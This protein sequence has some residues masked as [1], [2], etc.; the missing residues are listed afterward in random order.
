MLV[1]DASVA[2]KWVVAEPNSDRALALL[3]GG[4]VFAAPSLIVGEIGNV[5]WKRAR[6]GL[7]SRDDAIAVV[8]VAVDLVST[9]VPAEELYARA[10]HLA[11]DLDHP[12][13]DCFYLALAVREEARL[14]TA[15]TRLAA[16]AAR[17]ALRIEPL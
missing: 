5:A 8:R 6:G 9:I 16:L 2:V 14:A 10:L 15:D 17:L 11:I 7:I 4:Q 3:T 13:Y 12:I 1:V